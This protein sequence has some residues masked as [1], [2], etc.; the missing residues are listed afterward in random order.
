MPLE[1][2][3]LKIKKQCVKVTFKITKDE[4]MRLNQCVRGDFN[5]WEQVRLL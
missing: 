3:L 5:N 4:A 2:Q 1:K